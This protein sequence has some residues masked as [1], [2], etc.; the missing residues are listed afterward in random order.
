MSP[1]HFRGQISSS[2]SLF[3]RA[4]IAQSYCP[5]L[6]LLG[7]SEADDVR[8]MREALSQI[9]QQAATVEAGE[10]GTTFRFLSLRWAREP[11]MH[12]LKAAPRLMQR[13]QGELIRICEQLG[14]QAEIKRQGLLIQSDGWKKPATPVQVDCSLSSQYASA[15]VLNAW[16][17]DFDLEFE[18]TGQKVSE[19]YFLMT[20]AQMQQLGMTLQ[21]TANGYVIPRGQKVKVD[22]MAIEPDLSSA[23]ALVVAGFLAGQA[24]IENFPQRSLQPDRAFLD[25]LKA[26]KISYQLDSQGLRI[27]QGPQGQAVEWN[28]AQCPDLFPVLAVLCSFLQGTS[29]FFGAPH[30]AQK[31]SHRINKVSEL[32]TLM[33]VR[34][35][36]REDGMIIEGG[37]PK[38][39]ASFSFNPD[40]DHRMVMASALFKLLGF[41]VQIE[42]PEAVN[43]SFPEFWE[44][45]GIQP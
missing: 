2:K 19:D 42:D 35:E 11:G 8:F 25:I 13:P 33:G 6:R 1:W 45:L 14:V 4:L 22:E 44:I 7:F 29:K 20:I 5:E 12:L 24:H 32:L 39:G 27:S 16:N 26:M 3:N 36:A 23:F 31:E 37:A 40:K 34:H 17:L 18:L 28:L 41:P 21:K 30:L 38:P 9:H 15:L 10:G 43:K